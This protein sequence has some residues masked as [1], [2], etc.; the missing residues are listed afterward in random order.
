MIDIAT[1]FK[2]VLLL[3]LMLIPGVILYKAHF[4]EEKFAKGLANLVLYIAQPMMI[5]SPYIRDF[6]P[7]LLP[8]MIGVAVFSVLGH[9][10]FF[11]VARL[12][13]KKVPIEK[14]RV[15][16]FAVLF[17]NAGYM[18]IPLIEAL[19]GSDAAIYA[20]VYTIGFH[21]FVW[22]VGCYLYTGDRKYISPKKMLLNPAAISVYVGLLF[23]F[24]P[25]NRFLPE[26]AISAVDMLKVLVAPLSMMLVGFHLAHADL[27]GIFRDA[28]LWQCILLRL[29]VC[30]LLIFGVM[31]LV[32]LTGLY[33]S[34]VAFTVVLLSSATPAAT[35]VSMFAEKFDCDTVTA[36]KVVPISTVC[37]LLSMPLTALLLRLL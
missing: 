20:T 14:R 16:Q 29:F 25:V 28:A 11:A 19:L 6:D 24:L 18:G 15:L 23:F 7:R 10:L 1:L 26:I 8:G 21:I 13:F 3:I 4:G 33:R 5:V 27:R 12:C 34:E 17:S 9:L 37:S 2:Q 35:A 36:G 30:P 31:K 32:A 22:S